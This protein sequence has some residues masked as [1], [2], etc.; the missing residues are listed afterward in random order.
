MRNSHKILVRELEE[1]DHLEDLGIERR[2]MLKLA[3]C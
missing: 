3:L 2:T 1:R